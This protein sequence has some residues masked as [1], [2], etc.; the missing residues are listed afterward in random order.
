PRQFH[1]KREMASVLPAAQPKERRLPEACSWQMNRK[2]PLRSPSWF[3][4]LASGQRRG[5]WA[6]V[7]R[8]GLGVAELPYAFFVRRRNRGYDSGRSEVER[9]DVP[10]VSV[11]NLTVGGTGKT[12]FVE[13]LARWF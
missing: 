10:V 9:L 11:G 3:H 4:N 13:W 5:V 6:G 12:P 8:G 7:V 2:N 1:R